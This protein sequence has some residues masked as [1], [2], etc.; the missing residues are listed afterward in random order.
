MPAEAFLI[1]Q[2]GIATYAQA[3]AQFGYT[4]GWTLLFS[5][6]LMSAIQQISARIGRVTGHGLAGNLRRHYPAWLLRFSVTLLLV[7]NDL[8][9]GWPDE[10]YIHID[11]GPE[12]HA[13]FSDHYPDAPPPTLVA[14]IGWLGVQQLLTYGGSGYFPQR[15]VRHYIKDGLL[16]H[17]PDSPQFKLPA[18]MVFP[19]DS[20]SDSATLK[21][22]LDGLRELA[23]AEQS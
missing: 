14:N 6:P 22:A 23:Q 18:Y 21:Q 19:R 4:L 16:W 13:Q 17:V 20:E 9:R 11:W 7:A 5:Y 2:R 1:V 15:L 10:G 8:A 3:G 12:F